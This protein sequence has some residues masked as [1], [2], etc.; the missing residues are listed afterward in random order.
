MRELR[1]YTGCPGRERKLE[2]WV[3][4]A[5]ILAVTTLLPLAASE[6]LARPFPS[7]PTLA[8]TMLVYSE[9]LFINSYTFK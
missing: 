8:R 1:I 7:A 3:A 9:P 4:T 2:R 6:S 5:V